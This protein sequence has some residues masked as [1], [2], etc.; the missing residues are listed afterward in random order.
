MELLLN[1]LILMT[2][3]QI[4][5]RNQVRNLKFN[6]DRKFPTAWIGVLGRLSVLGSKNIYSARAED[7]SQEMEII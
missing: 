7:G 4:M 6:A 3:S 5:L 2:T 1:P